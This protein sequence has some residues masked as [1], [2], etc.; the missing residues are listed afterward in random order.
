[1]KIKEEMKSI[2]TFKI[3]ENT[4]KQLKEMDKSLNENQG[5]Y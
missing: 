4:N 1:M 5:K 3:P 2:N